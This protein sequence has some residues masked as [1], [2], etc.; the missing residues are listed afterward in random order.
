MG[1]RRDRG[2]AAARYITAETGIPGLH[3]ETVSNLIHAPAPYHLQLVTGKAHISLPRAMEAL[4]RV[5]VP[6]VIRHN[7]YV[8]D[9]LRD[10]W[11]VMR[12]SD[13][14]PL[15]TMHY[16]ANADRVAALTERG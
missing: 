11:M 1:D 3:Y 12:A 2:Q 15:L 9:S 8:S 4:P 13:F 5:G 14:L 10:A 16:D 6:I 7:S